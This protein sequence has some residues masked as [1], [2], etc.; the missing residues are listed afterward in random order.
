M[1]IALKQALATH[2]EPAYRVAVEVGRSPAW[3]SMVIREMA[4][5]SDLEKKKLARLIGRKVVE[6]FPADSRQ[7]VT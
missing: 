2:S 3:L 6:L 7:E 5:P 1:N 4:Q